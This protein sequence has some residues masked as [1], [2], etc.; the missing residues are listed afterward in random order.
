MMLAA[1]LLCLPDPAPPTGF[2]SLRMVLDRGLP[3]R[4]ALDATSVLVLTFPTGELA[5]WKHADPAQLL[6]DET[7]EVAPFRLV[8]LGSG[9][10]TMAVPLVRGGRQLLGYAGRA[11]VEIMVIAWRVLVGDLVGPGRRGG[12]V[13]LLWRRV[14]RGAAAFAA[15]TARPEILARLGD[16]GSGSRGIADLAPGGMDWERR[17][18]SR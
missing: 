5:R 4:A 17:H 11:E 9:L 15:P 7:D 6:T 10:P 14:D 18:G 16:D 13:S 3:A 8:Y 1:S 12:F 2:A